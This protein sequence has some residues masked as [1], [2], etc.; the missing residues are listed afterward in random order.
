MSDNQGN[1]FPVFLRNTRQIPKAMMALIPP[2][3][4]LG[5]ISRLNVCFPGSLCYITCNSLCGRVTR[6]MAIYNLD[7]LLDQYNG[8]FLI[9]EFNHLFISSSIRE[10]VWLLQRKDDSPLIDKIMQAARE[11]DIHDVSDD[12]DFE[13]YSGGQKAILACLLTLA[14]IRDRKIHGLKL[15]LNNILDSI[16][17]E[18]RSKLIQKFK[19]ICST[20]D[21]KVFSENNGRMQEII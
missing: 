10:E 20:R 11:F 7:G 18:N 1:Q 15:L 13:T 9:L 12:R 8:E 16:S 2:C 14:L 6:F 5:I 3:S 21:I 4:R 19:E 17:A